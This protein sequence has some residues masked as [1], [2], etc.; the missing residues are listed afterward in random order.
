MP[1][2]TCLI[3]LTLQALQAA[4]EAEGG[5][6]RYSVAE[7]ANVSLAH[8]GLHAAGLL[9]SHL[10]P[11]SATIVL[12]TTSLRFTLPRDYPNQPPS[13]LLQLGG[14]SRYVCCCTAL[15]TNMARALRSRHHALRSMG[16]MSS[17]TR[18]KA[19]LCGVRFATA[20]VRLWVPAVAC[21]T[22]VNAETT[23]QHWLMAHA[24]VVPSV[25][26]IGCITRA[27]YEQ[28]QC[29]L[30]SA[31]ASCPGECCML[32]V[33]EQLVAAQAS[34]HAPHVPA[35][36]P[37]QGPLTLRRLLIWY[38][39]GWCSCLLTRPTARMHDG[40][41][42]DRFHHIASLHKRKCIV[43]W[44]RELRL[45][46][47]SKPGWPG[48]VVVEGEAADAEEFVQR[49]RSLQWQVRLGGRCTFLAAFR[50]T[51]MF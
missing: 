3:N 5:T 7:D 25:M 45:G 23:C 16:R 10:D 47:Y 41:Q 4:V 17:H 2:I 31:A 32:L 1:S 26:P 38:V 14:A 30:E 8:A 50:Y 46:G 29:S 44:A 19:V 42:T 48:V 11:L 34:M 36:V 27:A 6:L 35:E 21:A 13:L 12:G 9:P 43:G 33:L 15:N 20:L 40:A 37:S 18:A 49:V 22:A 39:G 24:R 51:Q 28:V